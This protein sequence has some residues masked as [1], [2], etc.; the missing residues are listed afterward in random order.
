MLPVT[1]LRDYSKA[2][3]ALV[4]VE[5]KLFRSGV[6]LQAN[7]T[8]LTMLTQTAA[9]LSERLVVVLRRK[10]LLPMLRAKSGSGRK[11]KRATRH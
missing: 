5:M 7:T 1:I 11:R 8:D 2:I 6:M 3:R 10:L 9:T 4:R